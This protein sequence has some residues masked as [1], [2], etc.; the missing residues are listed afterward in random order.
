MSPFRRTA[1]G[2]PVIALAALL[3]T[4]SGL[5]AAAAPVLAADPA[6]ATT[7]ATGTALR[8][9]TPRI[10][11]TTRVGSVLRAK[12]YIPKGVEP[13]LRFDWYRGTVRIGGA[14]ASSYRLK[15][16]DRG[17]TIKVRAIATKAGHATVAKGSA[18][19]AKI[20]LRAID[21]PTSSR[22]VVNKQRPLKP[23]TYAPKGLRMPRGLP[24]NGQ[25]VRSTVATAVEKMNRAAR[26]AGVELRIL[27]GYRSYRLQKQTFDAYVAR[28][29]RKAAETYS[30]RPGYSEH[31]TGFALDFG[32]SQGCAF[33]FCFATTKAGKWLKKH[34]P[35]Y[36]FIERYPKGFT[37]I[38]GYIWEPYHFRYVGRTVAL[39]MK[40]RKIDTLERYNGLAS[41]PRY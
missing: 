1:R 24:N 27:S 14:H 4:G 10:S 41:A 30:A 9:G 35:S 33:D 38:T 2:L 23:K 16:K 31:Q 22:V 6:A 11:G 7:G 8:I 19:T 25:P 12:V 20:R 17:H 26:K 13:K 40:R 32:G 5:P 28:D 18:R 37:R 21:D 36:G 39:D 34:G 29:G 15:A 3:A